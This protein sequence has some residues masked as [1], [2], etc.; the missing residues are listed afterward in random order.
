MRRLQDGVFNIDCFHYA[1]S[2]CIIEDILYHYRLNAQ[3]DMFRKLP[4]NYYDL[5]RQFSKSFIERK[6]NW[7]DF[8]NDKITVFFLNELGSCLENTFSAQWNMNKRERNKYF[9]DITKDDFFLAI[10]EEPFT[11]S[12]Y[13]SFLIKNLKK[14]NFASLE[15]VI[16][17]KNFVKLRMQRIFYILKRR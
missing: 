9:T 3:T 17:L 4:K 14:Q 16:K 15:L 10:I 11:L 5:I 12:R 1:N 13:R 7:G 8:S 6:K 2:C